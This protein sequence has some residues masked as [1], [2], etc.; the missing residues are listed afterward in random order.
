MV[1]SFRTQIIRDFCHLTT[2]ARCAIVASSG[3]YGGG[4]GRRVWH[5]QNGGMLR[6]R[7]LDARYEHGRKNPHTSTEK[8]STYIGHEFKKSHIHRLKKSPHTSAGILKKAAYIG[9][10]NVHIHR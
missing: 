10:K 7:L 1:K 2:G 3:T 5:A 6:P 8:K 4:A 9:Q